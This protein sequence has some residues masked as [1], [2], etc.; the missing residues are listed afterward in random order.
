MNKKSEFLI[1]YCDIDDKTLNWFDSI[2]NKLLKEL[3]EV[4]PFRSETIVFKKI[5]VA[6]IEH[7][8]M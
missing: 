2:M 1:A 7:Y 8:C 3:S 4:I 5:Y 6:L